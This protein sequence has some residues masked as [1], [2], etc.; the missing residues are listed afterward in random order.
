[1]SL[2][3]VA[4]RMETTTATPRK[5]L[6][7]FS[8]QERYQGNGD[9]DI[10]RSTS[11]QQHCDQGKGVCSPHPNVLRDGSLAE[12]KSCDTSEICNHHAKNTNVA[13]WRRK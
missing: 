12:Y 10:N 5:S 8:Q 1:M 4:R 13:G 6:S 11:R 9:D 7:P 2:I 3:T